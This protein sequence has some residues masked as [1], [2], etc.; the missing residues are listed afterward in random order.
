MVTDNG[1]NIVKAISDLFR[2]RR[3]LPCFP[4]T[5][6]LEAE[7]VFQSSEN[8]K[9]IIENVKSFVTFCKRSVLAADQLR[10]LTRNQYLIQCVPTIGILITL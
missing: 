3:S 8:L 4:H 7:A 1:K 5:L 2:K 10:K 6:K 9:K